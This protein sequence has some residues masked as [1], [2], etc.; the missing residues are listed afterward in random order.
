[1]QLNRQ[2]RR[3]NR[4]KIAELTARA[5]AARAEL[6]EIDATI[7][8]HE[9]HTSE[10]V[11][12]A[13]AQIEE[14]VDA[15]GKVYDLDDGNTAGDIDSP[16]IHDLVA[17][18]RW[19]GVETAEQA[20]EELLQEVARRSVGKSDLALLLTSVDHTAFALYGTMPPSLREL[21]GKDLVDGAVKTLVKDDFY[22]TLHQDPRW[23][24][25]RERWIR[26]GW[27]GTSAHTFTA[28]FVHAVA[29]RVA[30]I[31]DGRGG[32]TPSVIRDTILDEQLKGVSSAIHNVMVSAFKERLERE[33]DALPRR[34][35]KETEVDVSFSRKEIKQLD[36]IAD[37]WDTTRNGAMQRIVHEAVLAHK[38]DPIT[39]AVPAI[40]EDALLKELGDGVRNLAVKKRPDGDPAVPYSDHELMRRGRD[41]WEKSY[42]RG[43]G[44]EEVRDGIAAFNVS[45]SFGDEIA[46]FAAKWAVHAFQRLMTS[47]TFAAAL[48]CSDVQREVLTGIER[49]WDAFLVIV[50]NGMLGVS[51]FEFSRVLVATYSY[52]AQ[53]I[54]VTTGGPDFQLRVPFTATITDEA[55]TLADLLVSGEG[56]L[57]EDAG[58]R[59]CLVMAKRLVAGLLLNLQHEPNF[60]VRRVESRERKKGREAE[61]EHRIVTVGSP[62]E[63]DCRAAVREYV[64][65]GRAGRK[66]GP[67]TVQ[68]MVRG[69]FRRQVH[70]VGRM[71]RKVIWI[72][73][74]WR[75]P[76]AALI[77][78]R[79]KVPS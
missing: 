69:H 70:G 45:A 50:P 48:M 13:L 67:P 15:L 33:Y 59:R 30:Q 72:H 75:G 27:R 37:S 71:E 46:T 62:I 35:G 40:G 31:H 32:D 41:L 14:Y 2:S 65:H 10:L 36:T 12:A 22:K 60:K 57:I 1:M 68:V 78:T 16:K 19:H 61:P 34:T 79:A 6:V 7:L 58:S 56:D 17:A 76:E 25:M 66:H 18:A 44:D 26:L 77:Q 39:P 29:E 4:R 11:T 38:G 24:T 47:H 28:T 74:F 9:Q 23:D 54:L 64:E 3:Q 8:A 53:M 55:P 73:P 5:D 51:K 52:G 21:H 42:A 20:K 49:Q 63:I 43:W